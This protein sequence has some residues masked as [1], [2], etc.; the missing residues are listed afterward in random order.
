MGNTWANENLRPRRGRKHNQANGKHLM[1]VILEGPLLYSP[2][3]VAARV[4]DP[5]PRWGSLS[6]HR[7]D[8][9][10]PLRMNSNVA[11][12]ASTGAGK[13]NHVTK[14][15]AQQK[16]REHVSQDRGHVLKPCQMLVLTYL[17]EKEF[18]P[19]STISWNLDTVPCN[20]DRLRAFLLVP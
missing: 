1:G 4:R 15:Q 12:Q 17:F 7:E 19:P 2:G 18:Q 10:G 6:L 9:A 11:L 20:E 14:S 16:E 5:A 3:E 8:L 13:D